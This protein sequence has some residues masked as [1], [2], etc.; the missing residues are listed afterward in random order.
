MSAYLIWGYQAT[1]KNLKPGE[2]PSF[3]SLLLWSVIDVI[4]WVN[5]YRAHNDQTLIATYTILTVAL[6][7]ILV[8]MRRFGWSK[9]DTFV[10]VIAFTCLIVSYLT[11]PF[12]GVVCGSLSIAS[13]G[14][15]N[16]IR[17]SKSSPTN[18]LYLTIF[19]FFVGPLVSCISVFLNS[20]GMKDYVY[21]VV[22][23]AYWG[24]AFF[25]ALYAHAKSLKKIAV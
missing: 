3:P 5:T 7:L 22:A 20:G 2:G 13:A 18:L 21:P 25:I 1:R 9:T 8:F 14:I 11:S 10:A 16:L 23:I 15:P 12:V 19:F 24:V 4:M 17:I 6:T